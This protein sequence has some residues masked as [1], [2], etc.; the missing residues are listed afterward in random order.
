MHIFLCS[1]G[2]FSLAIPMDYVSSIYLSAK[3][4]DRIIDYDSKNRN[5]YFSLPM[6][7]KIDDERTCHGIVLKKDGK[8]GNFDSNENEDRI[9]LISTEILSE[10]EI[11][12]E[13]FRPV[14]GAL[15][16]YSNVSLFNGMFFISHN[17]TE[18]DTAEDLVL[19]LNPEQL[20]K[21]IKKELNT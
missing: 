10:K 3:K 18:K 19:L 6:F 15:A 16:L 9:I 7:F 1:Y 5:T 13:N 4:N 12:A 20:V 11:P 2:N 8:A 14:P 17:V 21:T